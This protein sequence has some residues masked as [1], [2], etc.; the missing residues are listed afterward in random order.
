MANSSFLR[1]WVNHLASTAQGHAPLPKEVDPPVLVEVPAG[2]TCLTGR[3]EPETVCLN[4][5]GPRYGRELGNEQ[6]WRSLA[7][8][9]I[10]CDA[11]DANLVT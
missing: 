4:T 5:K 11:V 9:S 8:Y 7:G 2:G 3:G 10:T 6:R 1:K